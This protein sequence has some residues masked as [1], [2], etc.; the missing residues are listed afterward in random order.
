L[1]GICNMG[2]LFW[3]VCCLVHSGIANGGQFKVSFIYQQLWTRSIL[4]EPIV[5]VGSLEIKPYLLIDAGY[6]SWNCV[7]HN[8]KPVDGNLDKIMLDLQMNV[9][10][11]NMEN[12]F[13]I[14]KN[15]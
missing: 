6:V 13:G 2:K 12:V 11:V 8:F 1:Q 14:L 7:L 4:R 9:S 5:M 3:N 10:R 15:N